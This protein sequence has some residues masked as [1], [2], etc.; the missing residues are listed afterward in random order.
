[1]RGATPRVLLAW[2]RDRDGVRVHVGDLDLRRRGARAPFACP[3]CGEPLVARLGRVRARHFAHRPGSG[4]PL[5]APETALHQ[6]AKERLLRLC[7]E[8]FAGSRR[9]TVGARCPSCRRPAPLDLVGA[10]DAAALEAAVGA[11]RADVLVTRR[12]RPSLAIEVRVAHE[13]EPEKAEALAAAGVPVVEVDA[14]SEWEAD[15][16]GG[17]AVRCARSLG[18]ERCDACATGARA[19]D[20]RARGGEE[21]EVA[22]LEA[23]RARGLLGPPPGRPLPAPPPLSAADRGA[24]RGAF[25]CP[26]CRGTTLDEGERIVRHACP[27]ALPRA[28]AWRG[29]DG[30]LVRMGW[31][32]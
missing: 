26:D 31:W 16:A 24:L 30:A 14:R 20:G 15:V 23:Y 21:A 6:N 25:R 32:G 17:T 29:Y 4:C 18:F 28:V 3:R 7:E 1:M 9:V 10:G 12:G 8:A 22:E 11:R 13:V 2:A 5:T 27:A 19:E